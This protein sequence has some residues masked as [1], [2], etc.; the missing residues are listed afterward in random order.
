MKTDLKGETSREI[1][2]SVRDMN[3][4]YGSKRVL[5]SV[6]FAVRRG[7]CFCLLGP[8]GA[9]KTTT[10]RIITGM[11]NADNGNI[12]INGMNASLFHKKNKGFITI[13]PQYANL[14][15]LLTVEENL[16]FFGLLQRMKY[17]EIQHRIAYLLKEFEIIHL[18]KQITYHCSGGEYQR[19]LVAR[20]FIRPTEIIFM[21]EPTAGIDIL[22]KNR[23]WD[24]FKEQNRQG[25]T[26]YLNTHDLNE[27]EVLSDHIGFLF[28]GKIIAIDT[29]NRLKALVR[30]I[31]ITVECGDKIRHTELLEGY[32]HTILNDNKIL[33][34]IVSVDSQIIKILGRLSAFNRI[35]NIDVTQPSLNDVFKQLGV[36]NA[37]DSMA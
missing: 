22:F 36:D 32:N 27:A 17:K 35:I 14:D 28:N 2:I 1:A 34:K 18:K 16:I 37:C 7:E 3:K 13:I 5:N 8:N 23:L 12:E 10:M 15:P 31:N 21:D 6:T 4:Y 25:A 26:I 30:G 33:L 20:A 29:P 24:F 19:L 9:G 11:Q